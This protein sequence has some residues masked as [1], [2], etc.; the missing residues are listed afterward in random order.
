MD[1][2]EY[3]IAALKTAIYPNKGKNYVYPVLG[4]CGECGEVSEKFKKIIRDNDG[5]IT[6]EKK[7]EIA[8]ELGDVMWY[9]A[10]I[11]SEL[12]ITLYEI[13]ILNLNKLNKRKEENKLHGNGDN[14]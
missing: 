1:I 13:A 2:N 10:A 11:C 8:N 6:A 9:L 3:Q 4:L 14:R 7:I 12:N 5:I